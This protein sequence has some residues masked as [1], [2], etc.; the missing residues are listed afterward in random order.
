MAAMGGEWG[1]RRQGRGGAGEGYTV[2]SINDDAMLTP[3]PPAEDCESLL[4]LT[5]QDA[6]AA[7]PESRTHD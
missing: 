3:S 5:S 2:I 7:E 4:I 6:L 1:G